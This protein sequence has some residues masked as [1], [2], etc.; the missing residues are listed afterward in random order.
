MV[1]RHVS[2]LRQDS[3]GDPDDRDLLPVHTLQPPTLAGPTGQGGREPP[4][5][6]QSGGHCPPQP[7]PWPSGRGVLSGWSH[8]D[9]SRAHTLDGQHSLQCLTHLPVPH[10]PA[11]E[12]KRGATSGVRPALAPPSPACPRVSPRV[13]SVWHLQPLSPLP[14]P[15]RG[16]QVQAS[17]AQ[18]V[19]PHSLGRENT[20][21][22]PEWGARGAAPF[23][24]H[25]P[26]T[27]TPPCP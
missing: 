27:E 2:A 3:G 18:R 25:P 16:P 5:Q 14:V 9:P 6:P 22:M 12:N 1:R 21:H 19:G 7:P 10:P 11:L 23:S 4:G 24:P 8:P 13:R 17:A 15:G 20:C 26:A